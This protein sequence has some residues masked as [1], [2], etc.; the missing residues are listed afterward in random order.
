MLIN[1]KIN[2][3]ENLINLARKTPSIPVGIVCAHHQSSMES[4]KQ[5][6]ELGLINPSFIG[7]T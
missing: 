5:A 3:P 7:T 2:I 4:S 1:K 6:Y